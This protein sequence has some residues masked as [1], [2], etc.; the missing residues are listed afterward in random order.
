MSSK[1]AGKKSGA[2]NA[3]A[4]FQDKDKAAGGSGK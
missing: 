4:M 2:A 1:D 3:F